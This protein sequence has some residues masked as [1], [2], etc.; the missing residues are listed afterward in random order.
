MY[1]PDWRNDDRFDY[2][3]RLA[4]LLAALLADRRDIEGSVS[5]V[6]GAFRSEVAGGADETAMAI[7]M[8][9]HAAELVAVR[10]SEPA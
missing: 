9:R 2:T 7:R 5:T 3:N 6:P 10:V 1:Q 8:L 4:R